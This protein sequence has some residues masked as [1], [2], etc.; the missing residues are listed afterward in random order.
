MLRFRLMR[1]L[2]IFGACCAS[3]L[4]YRFIGWVLNDMNWF[5][6]GVGTVNV[7]KI[8]YVVIT[9]LTLKDACSDK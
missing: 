1:T 2:R 6:A 3:L 5:N 9:Y 7:T 4:V 8:V